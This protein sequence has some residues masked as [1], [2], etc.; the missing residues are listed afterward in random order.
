[1]L[2]CSE[3][4]LTSWWVDEEIG[5]AFSKERQL[6]DERRQKIRTLVPI[7][8][9]DFLF[10][11]RCESGKRRIIGGRCAANFVGW[12][13]DNAKFENGFEGIVNA[14]RADSGGKDQ[15]PAPKL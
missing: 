14:L 9:D 2:C 6:S 15:P 12:D 4:S 7:N 10:S 5:L 1:L 13:K 8:L 3:A 11:D